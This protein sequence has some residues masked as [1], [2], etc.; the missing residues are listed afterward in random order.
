MTNVPPPPPVWDA[1]P[2]AAAATR[3]GGFWIRVVAYLLDGVLLY[4][5]G[6]VV[7]FVFGLVVGFVW[8]FVGVPAT[9]QTIARIGGGILGL[10]L[11][12]LYFAVLESS[13]RGATLGKRAVGLRVVTDQGQ[14]L[15]F[16]NAFGR[17]FAKIVSL[18]VL[19]IGFLMVAF[20]DRKRGLHDMMAGTLVIHNR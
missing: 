6:T 9:A 7:G 2:S 13:E 8:H 15:T 4:V 14:R 1:Q 5:V 12:I 3:Y 11:G 17:Y 18:L 19:G 10:G 20:T 16:A